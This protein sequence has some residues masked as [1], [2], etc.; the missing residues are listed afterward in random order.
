MQQKNKRNQRGQ[1]MME[2]ALFATLAI[3][4]TWLFVRSIQIHRART[5]AIA[6]AYACTQYLISSPRT[7]LAAY[8]AITVAEKNLRSRTGIERM[9]FTI[10]VNRGTTAQ[11]A[12]C[13][14]QYK[15]SLLGFGWSELVK[16]SPNKGKERFY[17]QTDSWK[18]RWEGGNP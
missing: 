3:T 1:A 17:A 18:A 9:E 10:R 13:E 14:V 5:A 7:D 8:N 2:F 15:A 11:Q 4:M 12:Y 6:S 16:N